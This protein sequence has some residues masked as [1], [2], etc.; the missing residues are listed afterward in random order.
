[1]P[2]PCVQNLAAADVVVE[3][4]LLVLAEHAAAL[5]GP[6]RHRPAEVVGQHRVRDLVRQHAVEE[7]LRLAP[8]LHLLGRDAD[9]PPRRHRS[10]NVVAPPDC[11]RL[12]STRSGQRCGQ[13]GISLPSHSPGLLAAVVLGEVAELLGEV[14]VGGGDAEVGGLVRPVPVELAFGGRERTAPG[15]GER[16][17]EAQSSTGR[18]SVIPLTSVGSAAVMAADAK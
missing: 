15:Q 6:A 8:D 12:I 9:R 4:L 11:R 17:Y 16:R 18:R 10:V 2:R 7:L 14:A 13:V 5:V 3:P 1:M